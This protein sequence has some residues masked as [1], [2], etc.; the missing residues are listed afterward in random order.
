M[1]RAGM[2]RGGGGIYKQRKRGKWRGRKGGTKARIKESES[3]YG[4]GKRMSLRANMGYVVH[5]D[6]TT[7]QPTKQLNS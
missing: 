6:R 2:G 3:A 5:I 7:D 1:G 4:G